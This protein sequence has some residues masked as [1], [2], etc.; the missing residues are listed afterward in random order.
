VDREAFKS[1]AN[2][3][4]DKILRFI[5][6]K[7]RKHESG[8]IELKGNERTSAVENNSKYFIYRLYK[9]GF[10]EYQLS[11][12]QDPLGQKEALEPAVYV[13]LN[14]ANE[15]QKYSLIGGIQEA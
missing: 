15:T 1:G 9:S 11:I 4:L 12:L 10:N 5:E 2:R 6:V 3:S 14:R 13:D 7:G 8:A